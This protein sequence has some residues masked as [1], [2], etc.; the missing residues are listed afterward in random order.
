MSDNKR[1]LTVLGKTVRMLIPLML[2]LGGG[3]AGAYLE[4]TAP[5]MKKAEPQRQVTVVET[6]TASLENARAL[7]SAMGTVTAAR[8]VTLKAR[9]AGTVQSICDRFIPGSLVDKGETLLSL[10]AADYQVVEKK[11]ESALADARA[12]LAIEQGSQNIA[13]EELKVLR[14]IS[15]Q[16]NTQTDLA[17]RKPQLTQALADVA[18]AEADLTQAKLNVARTQIITPFNAMIVER[19]VNIGAYVGAQESLVSLV[20]TDE[21]WIEAVVPLDE[22]PYIDMNYPGGCPVRIRSQAGTG[23]WEGRVIQE[24]GKLSDSSRMPVVIVA[25]KNPLG[26]R[27][28]PS[29]HPLMIGD[30]VYVD[31]TGRTLA[32]VVTLPRAALK[33][34]DTVWVNTGDTLDIRK[35]TLAWKDEKNVYVK[36]G[37]AQGDQVV[38]SDLSTPVQGM[39]LKSAGTLAEETK[40]PAGKVAADETTSEGRNQS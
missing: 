15:A 8:E 27:E 40:R 11:A 4:V 31:I 39:M 5:V 30:Y 34:D 35:V 6:T 28:N 25:V 10:D 23:S 24:T 26:T 17:L 1:E 7:V 3:A 16:Q 22:L 21:F 14:E 9:V 36:A 38:V 37:I 18:S 29:T 19:S 32:N 12:A 2:I 20:G 13:K 33:D